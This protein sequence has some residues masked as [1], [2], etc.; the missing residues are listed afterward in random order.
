[1]PELFKEILAEQSDDAIIKIFDTVG[2]NQREKIRLPELSEG[3]MDSSFEK[4]N[5]SLMSGSEQ[6]KKYETPKS[7]AQEVS[8]K[9]K[10]TI[11]TALKW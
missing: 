6:V 2:L 4:I 11:T 8:A 9:P 1:M 7:T 5:H 3:N 10:S